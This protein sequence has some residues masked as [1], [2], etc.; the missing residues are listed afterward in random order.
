MSTATIVSPDQCYRDGCY[1]MRIIRAG[2]PVLLVLN[3]KDAYTRMGLTVGVHVPAISGAGSI[4][5]TVKIM[6]G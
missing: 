3:A 4:V 2:H 5:G 6:G 1:E